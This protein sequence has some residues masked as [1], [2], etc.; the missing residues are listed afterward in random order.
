MVV[1][2]LQNEQLISLL[3][4]FQ[5]DFPD[6]FFKESESTY[7]DPVSNT[8]FYDKSNPK[9]IWSILHEIGH[10][11]EGHIHYTHDLQLVLMEKDAWTQAGKIAG[12]YGIDIDSEHIEDCLDSYRDWLH[13]RSRCPSCSQTGLQ[14]DNLN[15]RCLNCNNA[16]RV[17]MSRFCRS[18]RMAT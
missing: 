8:I 16:W 4:R 5:T 1:M 13:K 10:K 17:S 3:Q 14:D 11:L 9:V 2:S 6:I 15:Y 18:Y 12:K 7:W